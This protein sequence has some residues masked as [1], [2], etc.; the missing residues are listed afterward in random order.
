MQDCSEQN[1]G[2]RFGIGDWLVE[3]EALRIVRDGIETRLEP[4]VM[5]V[6]IYLAQHS[7]Q[8]VSRQQIEETVWRG[9][10]VGYDSLGS[11]IIKLRK[12]FNDDS[13]H[14]S[15]I[16]TIPKRGY[17]LI[18]PVHFG[19]R[20]APDRDG[21]R[22]QSS[23]KQRP[24]ILLVVLAI[25]LMVIGLLL[26]SDKW[27]D[28]PAPTQ[29][30]EVPRLAVL[31]FRNLSDD[32]RQAYFS[33]GITSDLITDLAKLDQVA[34]IARNSTFIYRNSDVDVR[35]IREE[36]D[37]SYVVEGSVRKAGN[38]VRI[39][40]R[41]V[42]AGTGV[43]IWAE[44]FDA[45]I[46]DV[47]SLQDRVVEKIVASME[48]TL[49]E[50]EK[51]RIA[52]A[53]T[54]SIAA[55]DYFLQGWQH[56]WRYTQEDNR[57]A[58]DYYAR[59]VTLDPGF[60]RAYANLAASY[61]FEYMNGWSDEPEASLKRANTYIDKATELEE[62]SPQVQWAVG[63]VNTY[64]RNYDVAIRAAEKAIARSPHF[65]DGYGLLATVLNYAG[66]PDEALQVMQKA[67]T[68]NP[69]HPFIYKMILGQIHFNLHDYRKAAD[70]LTQAVERNPSAQEV[71][72]WLAA[73]YAYLGDKEGATWELAQIRHYEPDLSVET[74]DRFIPLEDPVLRNHLIDGLIN[75]GLDL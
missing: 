20:T 11:T 26:V 1:S 7:G 13:R 38:E 31:P 55:Y 21:R 72:L 16:E 30:R 41:L 24:G 25:V 4:K 42:D 67:M 9:V 75:A 50:E 19:D 64:S 32:P 8:V 53:Y 48:I 63:I 34:V 46:D 47:F 27:I 65:A 51:E 40:A 49:S 33:D 56:F 39:S 3:P 14:P 28:E 57:Q 35:R 36:L 43:N 62:H 37:V 18:A 10:V 2:A 44:R 58:R 74:L 52:A 71:R 45:E 73:T 61:A 22:Q 6:L 12:A 54:D 60:A 66:R 59:A 5:Q 23:V 15:V 29:R 70:Y 17:R 68:L 69:R